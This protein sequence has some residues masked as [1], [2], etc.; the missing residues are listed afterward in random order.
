MRTKKAKVKPNYSVTLREM[1]V[2]ST[3]SFDVECNTYTSLTTAK[4][5]LVKIGYDL[6]ITPDATKI[7][8]TRNA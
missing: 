4:S 2:G 6:T 5:R 3:I 7:H 8:V 1:P